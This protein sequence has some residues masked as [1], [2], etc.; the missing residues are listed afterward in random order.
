MPKQSKPGN[1]KKR[2]P[3]LLSN[4]NDSV[5]SASDKQ[6]E[7]K[8]SDKNNGENDS[9]EERNKILIEEEEKEQVPEQ[10]LLEEEKQ[11]LAKEDLVF[12]PHSTL[13]KQSN[14]PQ[15]QK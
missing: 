12:L 5:E 14:E 3:Q 10:R 15:M 9:G 7:V 13:K 1:R 4:S 11:P 8:I 2:V 6:S